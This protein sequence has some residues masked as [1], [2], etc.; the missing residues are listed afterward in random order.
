[1]KVTYKNNNSKIM[2]KDGVFIIHRHKRE[3]D[4]FPK[5]FNVLEEKNYGI[6]KIIFGNQL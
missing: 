2:K 5:E 3:K 6:S 4:E 1:M